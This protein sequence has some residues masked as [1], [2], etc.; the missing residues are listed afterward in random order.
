M[1]G[2]LVPR[3]CLTSHLVM[4]T[5]A[6]VGPSATIEPQSRRTPGA[7]PAHAVTVPLCAPEPR[8]LRRGRTRGWRTHSRPPLHLEGGPRARLRRARGRRARGSAV[9]AVR[10]PAR[11]ALGA[12]FRPTRLVIRAS[13]AEQRSPRA[14]HLRQR[15]AGTRRLRQR[16]RAAIPPSMSSTPTTRWDLSATPATPPGDVVGVGDRSPGGEGE[17]AQ[18]ELAVAGASPCREPEKPVTG[19]HGPRPGLPPGGPGSGE[20]PWVF[21][22]PL[23]TSGPERRLLDSCIEAPERHGQSSAG[24]YRLI[25]AKRAVSRLGGAPTPT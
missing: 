11:A 6:A 7:S 21:S 19:P 25:A 12:L 8:P 4:V 3:L 22:G 14:C 23:T 20:A 2:P 24:G 16:H 13:D 10:L 15:P 1:N 5:M 9:A 18:R 17:P